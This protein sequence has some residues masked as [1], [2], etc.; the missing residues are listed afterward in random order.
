M[1]KRTYQLRLASPAFL[2]DVNQKGVWRTPPLKA[3]IR[4]WWRVA[5]APTLADY[6]V[7]E[8]KEREKALFGTAA[9]D[10]A[11]AN[12]QSRVRLALK[13]WNE[14]T[15]TSWP[16]DETRVIH[17]EVKDRNTGTGRR[18][19]AELYLGYGPLISS[20][21]TQLKS[22]AAL[23]AGE[24]NELR[25][26]YPCTEQ[27]ALE[28]AITLAHWFGTIGG[29]SR[30]G[31]GSL[32]FHDDA[33]AIPTLGRTTLEGYG[34]VRRLRDCLELDWPHAIGSDGKGALVW[35][36]TNDFPDWRRAMGFLA[37]T[38]IAF[39]TALKF[40]TGEQS[41]RIEERHALAYPVTR[42]SVRAWGNN[43]RIAN[44]LRFKLYQVAGDKLRA[45][46]YHTPCKPTVDCGN[47][48]LL[49]TW[50]KVHQYLDASS[51][52]ARLN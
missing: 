28:R 48:D 8:L 26:A 14:G 23:Q 19:G 22:G 6:S 42:H 31:W 5:A 41:P 16:G 38:K 46:I 37:E 27:Q 24:E 11:G 45:L 35:Q 49:A 50:Q 33:M 36:S 52:L 43:V 17:P 44:T 40:S 30:N 3:L 7:A 10:N 25:L 12:Q 2:G 34:C 29:R 15:C 4:E 9:D 1:I 51:A 21:N 20:P 32:L 13:H 39:R 18:V 47:V